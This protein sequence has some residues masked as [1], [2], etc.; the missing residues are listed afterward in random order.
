MFLDDIFNELIYWFKEISKIPRNSGQEERI[1]DFICDFAK[2]RGLEYKK[3]KLY[4]VIIKKE[5]TIGYEKN[6]AIIFQAHLDMVCEKT[7]ESLHNFEKDGIKI[8]QTTKT[9]T[10]LDTTL[11]ADDGIG[12]A[13]L[14]LLLNRNDILHPDIYCLFTV[15]EETGMDGARNFDYSEIN[16]KYLIN[17]DHE[18]E[19]TGIVGC[20]GGIR[21]KYTK[22]CEIKDIT[23]NIYKI[24]VSGLQG[25][26]SGDDIGKNR[27]NSNY[28][29]AAILN[30]LTH[31]KIVSFIGGNK[32]NVIPNYTEAIISTTS[33]N[34]QTTIDSLVNSLN[35]SEED[36]HLKIDVISEFK[37]TNE[38]KPIS[39][40]ESNNF[41]QL[42]LNLKQNV[43]EYNK[44]IPGLVETSGN[45]GI[46]RLEDGDISITEMI[47]SSDDEKMNS[48]KLLNNS[49]AIKYG[50]S[51][52]EL[53]SYPG[54]KFRPNT[55]IE[56]AYIEA[57]KE[58]HNQEKPNIC[59][60]HAGLE[61]GIIYKKMPNLQMI[62]IGPD[63]ENAHT[64]KE[65]LFLNSCKKYLQT[66]LKLIENL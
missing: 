2:Q 6:D 55:Y 50:Y 17:V 57:Y 10:A 66:L 41:I 59:V 42:L 48:I 27:L 24:I 44:D 28:V 54:W 14:L 12:I 34:I 15:Q 21:V 45:I 49:I 19:K 25:G 26:H 61:C 5:A 35:I 29:M 7:Q 38:P 22:K 18:D 20:A 64:V 11:G 47:R 39:I 30:K 40:E 32:D 4:N 31:L 8:I 60:I 63:I 62:S 16:A 58:V 36:K 13:T 46:V 53:S 52:F 9:L 37:K 51:S 33:N 3:D 56:K 23:G 1:C 43:I 65:T